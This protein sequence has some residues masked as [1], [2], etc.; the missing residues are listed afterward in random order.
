M[1]MTS[2]LKIGA[3]PKLHGSRAVSMNKMPFN[4]SNHDIER[5]MPRNLHIGLN[6]VENSLRIDDIKG[7]R[8]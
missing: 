1:K 4:L 5:S 2:V 3:A 8:P 6:K 7:A